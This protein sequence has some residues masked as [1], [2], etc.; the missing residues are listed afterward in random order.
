MTKTPIQWRPRDN[1]GSDWEGADIIDYAGR[2]KRGHPLVCGCGDCREL[3]GRRFR[4]ESCGKWVSWEDGGDVLPKSCAECYNLAWNQA[5]RMPQAIEEELRNHHRLG[6]AVLPSSMRGYKTDRPLWVFDGAGYRLTQ[7]GE[8]VATIVREYTH[9]IRQD[10][11][12][13]AKS[14]YEAGLPLTEDDKRS[15]SEKNR[16]RKTQS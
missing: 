2:Q 16:L 14:R 7:H 12:L 11:Y 4:C 9:E 3:C 13:V 1:Y 6:W 15:L 5:V 10:R 8:D